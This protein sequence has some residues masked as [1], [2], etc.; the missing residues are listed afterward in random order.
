MFLISYYL[1]IFVAK[2]LKK[3]NHEKKKQI[4]LIFYINYL[5]L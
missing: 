1:P 3:L 5:K 2:V 4:K